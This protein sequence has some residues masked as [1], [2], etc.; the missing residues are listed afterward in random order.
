VDQGMEFWPA[1]GASRKMVHKHWWQV[2][3][4]AILTG[5]MNLL[6]LI[7]CCV[8]LLFTAPIAIAA[9]MLAYQT[10]FRPSATPSA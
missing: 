7:C 8:G 3:G 5:L 6:G 4:L 9:M 1:M 10:I 2:F